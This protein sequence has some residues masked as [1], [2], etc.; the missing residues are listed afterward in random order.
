[1]TKEVLDGK[2][3][4]QRPSDA[5]DSQGKLKNGRAMGEFMDASN[6]ETGG[7]SKRDN[8]SWRTRLK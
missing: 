8:D 3:T 2:V 4:I 7:G 1:M 6:A 5:N